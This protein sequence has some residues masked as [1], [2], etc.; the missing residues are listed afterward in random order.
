MIFNVPV[1]YKDPWEIYLVDLG[2]GPK[3][4]IYNILTSN[5]CGSM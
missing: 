3:N 1:Y 5:S 2:Q 4:S